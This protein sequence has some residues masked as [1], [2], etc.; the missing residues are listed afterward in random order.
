MY[1]WW[2]FQVANKDCLN[3]RWQRNKL[4]THNTDILCVSHVTEIGYQYIKKQL[5]TN[6]KHLLIKCI[7]VKHNAGISENVW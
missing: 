4:E 1:S 5:V 7:K 6:Y 2:L 3:T